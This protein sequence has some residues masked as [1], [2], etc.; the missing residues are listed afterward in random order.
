[1]TPAIAASLFEDCVSCHGQWPARLAVRA[2]SIEELHAIERRLCDL[3]VLQAPRTEREGEAD[4]RLRRI[5][6]KLDLLA[7]WLANPSPAEVAPCVPVQLSVRGACLP[8]SVGPLDATA[9]GLTLADWLPQAFWLP[10]RVLGSAEGWHAFAFDPLPEGL[11]EALEK[12]VFRWHRRE[13][14]ES[15]RQPAG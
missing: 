12:L 7:A 1:M 5:E 9:L 10:G 13:L 6:A 2:V 14:A 11:A 15:R 4:E 3:A 8:D